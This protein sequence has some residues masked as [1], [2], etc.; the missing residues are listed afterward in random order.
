VTP[1]P[2]I[3]LVR[4]QL[5]ENIG[6]TARAMMNCNLTE[7]RLVNPR[8][9]WPLGDVHRERMNAA[10]SGADAVLENAK[11]HATTAE[12]MADLNT[13][14]AS[15]ARQR[16]MVKEVLTP[17]E[18]IKEAC[19]RMNEG[20]RIGLMFGPERTGLLNED[21]ICA[22]KIINIPANPAFSSFNLAQSVLIL[23][24]EWLMAQSTAPA[25]IL[26]IDHKTRA[27]TKA[28]LFHFFDHLERDLEETGFFTTPELKPTMVQN[29]RNTLLR[30]DMTEQEVRTWH[31]VVKALGKPRN[32]K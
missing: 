24:Y 8:D 20:M 18:A 2:V 22:E 11:I 19:T 23:A 17:R 15:T 5:V 30:A 21:L 14:Y 13:V 25:R 28:E 27:A 9:P 12:A 7:L 10:S 6:T 4:P 29:L 3:I 26:E 31:G 16:D 1:V 32:P